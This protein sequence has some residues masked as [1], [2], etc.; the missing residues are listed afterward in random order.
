MLIERV[1]VPS[2][3]A[4]ADVACA[5]CTAPLQ[6][7]TA[8]P[9]RMLPTASTIMASINVNPPLRRE[10]VRLHIVRVLRWRRRKVSRQGWP[11]SAG[12]ASL[13]QKVRDA[14][15]VPWDHTTGAVR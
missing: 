7:G 3:S 12:D 11:A 2:R 1:S 8:T 6:A 10:F 9:M 14:C 5:L 13:R 15:R 4:L